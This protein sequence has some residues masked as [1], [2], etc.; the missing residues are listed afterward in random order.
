[1]SDFDIEKLLKQISELEAELKTAKKYGLVWDKEHTK[2]EVVK[3]CETDIP[4]LIN[5][6]SKK[7]V[8]GQ[9]NNLLIEGDNYHVL[10]S[11]TFVLEGTINII[12][13]DPP[14]NTGNKD[15][16]YND[17][18]IGEDDGYR[19][20]KWLSFLEKRLILA[21]RLLTDDGVIFISIDEH[22][23]A[24][25]KL[26]CDKVFGE[27]NYIENFVWIKNATKNLS[28]TTSTNHEYVLCY[29]KN[30]SHFINSGD[31]FR[32][33]KEGLD[34]VNHLIDTCKKAGI[35]PKET[36]KRLNELYKTD[37]KFKSLL[38]YK[39]VDDDYRIYTSD[40]PSAPVA[41]GT[42]KNNFDIIHPITGKPCKKTNRGWGF[43]YEKSLEL[44]KNGMLLFG[45]DETRIPRLKRFLDT[46]QSE[47]QKSYIVDNTDG[48]K[49][50]QK[51]FE[52]NDIFQN[53]KPTTLIKWLIKSFPNNS[54]ILDFFAGSGTTGH[55]VIDLNKEDGGNRRFILCTNNENNI[56]EEVTYP[57]LKTVIT[58]KRQNG[59]VYSEGASTNLYYFKTD[60]IK[61]EA[62]TEQAKYNLVE[63]VD[64]LLCIAENIFDEKER[65]DYSS[66]FMSGD[67]HLFIYN[68]YYNVQKFNEF[69]NRVLSAEGEKIVYVYSSDNNVDESLI[70]GINIVLKPIPSKIY[71][72]YKEI[73]EDIKR[74]E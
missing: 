53:P 42:S 60:F 6:A 47:V 15:F 54:T 11:L 3:R 58:G 2:E 51:I 20:S 52:S 45:E 33:K 28:K 31:K 1:M 18:F 12:Y 22:E 30:I 16:V 67:K 7:I 59:S 66:H 63:K 57:R 21:K 44:I 43:S 56:C 69:K 38:L 24:Q 29:C 8:L 70:E 13:I 34:E 46:V 50:V 72:I 10:T 39:Y 61:D 74:D 40:N 14:Y 32:T 26:L 25:L 35:S 71:E 64:A 27:S 68:D 73:V 9:G 65:N 19:H 49:E 17:A 62:N 55:A 5:K 41:K 48:K 37:D 23:Y 36:E 4:V